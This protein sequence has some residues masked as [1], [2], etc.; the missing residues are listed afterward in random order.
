VPWAETCCRLAAAGK[1]TVAFGAGLQTNTVWT[2]CI[3][4]TLPEQELALGTVPN[5]HAILT[6]WSDWALVMRWTNYMPWG[7][8][9][10]L[11]LNAVLSAVS[12][13]GQR[14]QRLASQYCSAWTYG[15]QVYHVYRAF[16]KKQYASE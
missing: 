6:V 15:H 11:Q 16:H 1:R 10:C 7:T 2:L 4:L 5:R 12:T 8:E 13:A 9:C 14:S 3:S